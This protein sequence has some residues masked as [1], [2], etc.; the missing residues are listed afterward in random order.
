[1]TTTSPPGVALYR[2]RA[3]CIKAA[4]LTEENFYAVGD[5]AGAGNFRGLAAPEPYL[6]IDTLEGRVKARLGDYVIK[7]V[8]GEFYPCRADIFAE[9][10]EPAESDGVASWTVTRLSLTGALRS[11]PV[12][13][14]LSMLESE[15]GRPEDL[16]DAILGELGDPR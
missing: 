7:G 6:I 5:W 2:K 16:A 9:T 10:Y 15:G 4:R 8:K 1:M 13:A 3:V 11:L 12:T 14:V